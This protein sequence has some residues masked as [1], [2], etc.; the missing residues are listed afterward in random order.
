MSA[1]QPR[2]TLIWLETGAGGQLLFWPAPA[3]GLSPRLRGV[4]FP[5]TLSKV[6]C[7]GHDTIKLL[8]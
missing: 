4:P 2:A 1:W 5:S 3:R 7:Q 6:A 8:T